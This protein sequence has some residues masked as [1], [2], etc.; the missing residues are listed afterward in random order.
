MVSRRGSLSVLSL[1]VVVL[2]LAAC[3]SEDKVL[4]SAVVG[5]GQ[6][7]LGGGSKGADAG[8]G[9]ADADATVDAPSGPCLPE[10]SFG[11]DGAF[12]GIL[13]IRGTVTFPAPLPA[14]RRV[15]ISIV[16]TAGGNVRSQS[17]AAAAISDRFT[18]RIG[19]LTV[20][21]YVLRVQADATGNGVV[22]DPG[23]Y[24]GYFDGSATGPILNRADAAF[25]DIVGACVDGI[26]FGAG[27]KP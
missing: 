2:A 1:S 23:D 8:D 6:P 14:Q 18:Y 24:D 16:S 7:A 11:L 13:A 17:F 10:S 3:S 4:P 15:E 25:V 19:G 12:G 26:N 5:P 27:V 20:G 21:K 9:G 22:N